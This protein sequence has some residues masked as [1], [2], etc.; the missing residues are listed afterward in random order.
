MTSSPYSVIAYMKGLRDIEI[1]VVRKDKVIQ[2][3]NV[4]S[5]DFLKCFNFGMTSRNSGILWTS[6]TFFCLFYDM[7]EMV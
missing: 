5:G 3:C 4:N 1:Y 2:F 7:S 6:T